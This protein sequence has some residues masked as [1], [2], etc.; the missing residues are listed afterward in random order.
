LVRIV[1]A[2]DLGDRRPRSTRCPGTLSPYHLHPRRSPTCPR[3]TASSTWSRSAGSSA[4]PHE[5]GELHRASDRR[6]QAWRGAG[7]LH[8]RQPNQRL[9]PRGSW[10]PSTTRRWS[11]PHPGDNFEKPLSEPPL[12]LRNIFGAPANMDLAVKE[13]KQVSPKSRV[14]MLKYFESF[15]P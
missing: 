6:T 9:P 10:R 15:A 12:D 5:H 1:P 8:L 3:E 2:S 14:V 7:G 11:S 13:I 4:I